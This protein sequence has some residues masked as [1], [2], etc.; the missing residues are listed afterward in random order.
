MA[1]GL[2]GHIESL[3]IIP[4]PHPHTLWTNVTRDSAVNYYRTRLARVPSLLLYNH[5]HIRAFLFLKTT[6]Q[7]ILTLRCANL[8][9]CCP[10]CTRIVLVRADFLNFSLGG[11]GHAPRPP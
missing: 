7:I 2:A 10:E 3:Y 5:E 1:Q 9:I 11:W 6:L 4:R 8:R